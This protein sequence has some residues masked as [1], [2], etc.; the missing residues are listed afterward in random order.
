MARMVMDHILRGGSRR[1]P[2]PL[3]SVT[4]ATVMRKRL[5]VDVVGR[6][7][8][9]MALVVNEKN[10]MGWVRLT[11][12]FDHEPW[13]TAA[14][15]SGHEMDGPS[16]GARRPEHQ[17]EGPERTGPALRAHPEGFDLGR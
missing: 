3:S 16:G 17:R 9:G 15:E 13:R 10:L 8:P 6:G 14:R 7:Q 1:G 5:P 12:W 2:D 4:T 11:P